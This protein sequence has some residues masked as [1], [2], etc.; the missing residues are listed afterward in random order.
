VVGLNFERN[1]PVVVEE[2]EEQQNLALPLLLSVQPHPNRKT[3]QSVDVLPHMNVS[4]ITFS[5]GFFIQ[6]LSRV[7]VRG[8]ATSNNILRWL[9]T[10]S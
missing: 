2:I 3:K 6:T 9:L 10:V 5:V 7:T 4:S 8:T 1:E